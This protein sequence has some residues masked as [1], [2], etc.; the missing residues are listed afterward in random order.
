MEKRDREILRK[1]RVFLLDNIDS[2][3]RLMDELLAAPDMPIVT[4]N[5]MDSIQSNPTKE[6]RIGALLNLLPRRGPTAFTAFCAALRKTEQGFIAD[7]LQGVV[8][9]VEKKMEK[10][11]VSVPPEGEVDQADV[12][13]LDNKEGP[14]PVVVR[15]CTQEFFQ[16]KTMVTH[17]P[18]KMDA[19][20]RGLALILSNTRF[21]QA[22]QLLDRKGGEIDLQNATHLLEGLGFAT[23]P[24]EDKSAKDMLLIL[25]NF[26]AKEEH[27]TADACIVVLMSH[28]ARGLIY[29]TDGETVKYKDIFDMFNNKKCPS[30]QGKPKLFFIQA[31]RGDAV[32]KGTDA[33]DFGGKQQMQELLGPKTTG[34][35]QPDS[36]APLP[37]RTDMVFAYA[38]QEGNVS[39]R[40]SKYGSWY[41]QTITN[42][43]MTHAK[44][45]ELSSMLRMVNRLVSQKSAS[46]PETPEHHGGKECC[47][48]VDTL[49]HDFYFFPRN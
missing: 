32:D 18:Y 39:F 21:G 20:P 37:T 47:E 26:A 42:V 44:D 3:D 45:K 35:D 17:K 14:I 12:I 48:F 9:E 49:R 29:G 16:E 30:L 10:L 43:F 4:E 34:T 25:K 46:C 41:I 13:P 19:K 15:P 1:N 24:E 27:K 11:T 22:S 33:P 38:T 23:F 36:N 7:Q 8:T 31:C 5:M 40:N 6:R 2:L 28:G